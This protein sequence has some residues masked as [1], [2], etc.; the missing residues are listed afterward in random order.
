MRYACLMILSLT[1]I[2]CSA[3]DPAMARA[4]GGWTG[5]FAIDSVSGKADPKE[6]EAELM[7]GNLQLY[8]T[9]SKFKLEM[10]N[11]HQKFTIGGSWTAEK[12]RVTITA[13][14][15]AFKNPTEEEQKTFG[16][17]IIGPDEIRVAFGHAVVFDETEDKRRLTGLKMSIGKLIGRFEFE[18]P[19]PR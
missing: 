6:I 1:L 17:S 3:G 19:I 5:R 18:R 13:D 4:A 11:L 14:T 8:I 9:H 15:F 2:G 7:K 12:S 10:A 16:L